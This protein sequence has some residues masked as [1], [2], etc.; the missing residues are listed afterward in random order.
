MRQAM[1]TELMTSEGRGEGSREGKEG[2]GK[3]R[4][5]RGRGSGLVIL[6]VKAWTVLVVLFLYACTFT[7]FFVS[8]DMITYVDL[9]N[10]MDKLSNA[11][12]T[13]YLYNIYISLHR[14]LTC[15]RSV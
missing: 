13:S 1:T 14:C 3:G 11:F 5:G 4:E 10:H 6:V 2:S 7:Y 12:V 15:L 9:F 8:I